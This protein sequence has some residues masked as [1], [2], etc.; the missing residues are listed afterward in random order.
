MDNQKKFNWVTP[1]E[2]LEL[3]PKVRVLYTPQRIG[4]L[5]MSGAVIA[6][7][8]GRVTFID[9][10]DFTTFWKWRYHFDL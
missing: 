3:Y 2:L 4:Y 6:K 10:D 1:T 7:K 9:K 5:A 8:R